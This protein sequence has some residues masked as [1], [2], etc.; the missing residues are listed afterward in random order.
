MKSK[1]YLKTA[2]LFFV[3]INLHVEKLHAQ[4]TF[5]ANGSAGIGTTAPDA[6]ALLDMVSTSKGM[7]APRMTKN[8]RD[9][10]A[11]PATGLLI[12]Q[13][14]N[15]PGFYYFDGAA[16][17]AVSAKGANTSLSNLTATSINTDMLPANA[18]VNDLGSSTANWRAAYLNTGVFTSTTA[19]TMI[20][21]Q[22]PSPE[23][24]FY[25]GSGIYKGYV[26]YDG[27]NNMVF[28]T[29]CN[30]TAGS[31]KFRIACND[32]MTI[33][34]SG[35][36]NLSGTSSQISLNTNGTYSGGF[37]GSGADFYLN[38]SRTNI[39]QGTTIGNLILQTSSGTGQFTY[40]AGNVG[41]GT[42]SPANKLTVQ[43]G[44]AS[45]GIIHTNGTVTVGTYIGSNGGWLGTKSNHPL[46]FFANNSNALATILPNGNMGI[47]TI[48]PAYKLSVNGT[49]QAKE[50]RVETGWS[51]F[52]F[53]KNYKLRSLNE[54][55][56]YI[57]QNKHLPDI[58]SAKE[59]QQNGL[60]VADSQTK[61]MQKIEELTLYIIQMQKEIDQLKVSKQ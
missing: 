44:D 1:P 4:N 14:N 60:A 3:I 31:V 16:W 36:I 10:I 28:G 58:P 27:S 35:R 25:D 41:I 9:A 30:N 18:G 61:M 17:N 8:Q 45:Y 20:S 12:Y 6:S 38:A 32:V 26:W 57:Q 39:I 15:K 29:S 37:W 34:P 19:G 50:I 59:I 21:L 2:L 22:A 40:T 48:S 51:D 13:T 24:S 42:A 54:V 52:V 23:I 53:D 5:P 33:D 43:T 49:I 11:A 47:G 7:L 55:E 46:Y 56:N